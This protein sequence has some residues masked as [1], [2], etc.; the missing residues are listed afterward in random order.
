MNVAL[1]QCPL[2]SVTEPP[3][4]LAYVAA[5]LREAGI[6]VAIHDLEI[7]LFNRV[8]PSKRPL[9]APDTGARKLLG[10]AEMEALL[11]E[12]ADRVVATGAR[13]VGLSIFYS[14]EET[15]L[16]LARRIKARDARVRIVLGGPSCDRHVHGP[17]LV[18]LPEVDAVVL[19]EGERTVVELV[20]N[21]DEAT[22][23]F[24]DTPGALTKDSSGN[25]VDGGDRPIERDLDSIAFPDFSPFDLSQYARP[26][27]LALLTSRGCPNRCKFC[28]ERGFWKKF[29]TRSPENV[30]AEIKHHHDTLGVRRFYWVDSLINGDV[31][32]L[33]RLLDLI[34]ADGLKIRWYGMAMVRREMTGDLLAKMARAGC[35]LLQY[36]IESG[37]SRVRREM[38]KTSDIGLVERVV[39]DTHRAGIRVHGLFIVGYP[40]EKFSDFLATLRFIR[41]N[42][43]AITYLVRPTCPY[44]CLPNSILFEEKDAWGI[45]V[46]GEHYA[47]WTSQDGRNTFAARKRRLAAF[48]WVARRLK[49]PQEFGPEIF[50][51]PAPKAKRTDAPPIPETHRRVRFLAVA[52]PSSLSGKT[53]ARF[54]VTF[55][56]AGDATFPAW[57]EAGARPVGLGYHWIDA[58]GKV[59]VF[60][61]Q[62]RAYLDAPV[63]PGG[64]AALTIDVAP[65]AKPGA[66]V[67]RFQVVQDG[68]AWFESDPQGAAEVRVEVTA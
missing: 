48:H 22:G 33:D 40:T 10:D 50:E 16:D 18:A 3:L 45:R 67:L 58:G 59:A 49:I 41:R 21:F 8:D 36:G 14:T 2:W 61:D 11:G 55:A 12:W 44:V 13:I 43:D 66:H 65:P 31:R 37:S 9:F 54:A 52:G 62:V 24:G 34:L 30:F 47:E 25:V 39:R 51:D 4:G 32:K 7:E 60:D 53:P 29:R 20:K 15:S 6:A 42:R 56:N 5:A 27:S 38:G 19:G 17:R 28:S 63:A 57:R 23:R 35:V 68:V 26:G 46:D 64:E 1:V